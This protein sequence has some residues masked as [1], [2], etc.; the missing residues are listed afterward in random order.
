[1]RTIYLTVRNDEFNSEPGLMLRDMRQF[2][3]AAADHTGIGTAHDVLEHMNGAD[4]IGDIADELEALGAIWY[5]RGQHRM[6]SRRPK[7][8]RPHDDIASDVSRMAVDY[9][10]STE[11]ND[12]VPRTCACDAD[13][14]IAAILAIAKRMAR[15]ECRDMAPMTDREVR[16]ELA[17][18]FRMARARMRIGYRKAAR[19]YRGRD[20]LGTFWNIADVVGAAVKFPEC[21]ELIEGMQYVLK[22]DFNGRVTCEPIR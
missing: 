10:N 2:D 22:Y 4:K 9:V 12:S 17:H 20:V 15:A 7:F 18:Y 19:K 6:I 14:D 8:H 11:T 5:V 1:M 21:G 13:D 3:G 16:Q